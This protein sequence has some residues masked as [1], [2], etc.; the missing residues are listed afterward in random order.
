MLAQQSQLSL[1][2]LE[3]WKIVPFFLFRIR[4]HVYLSCQV[5]SFTHSL[6]FFFRLVVQMMD[7]RSAFVAFFHGFFVVGKL[8]IAVLLVEERVGE[9]GGEG[10]SKVQA[11]F[12]W[13]FV[14]FGA[15]SI[16]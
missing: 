12:S 15:G 1:S 5:Q 2:E 8:V 16:G 3:H 14:F 11:S 7:E 4:H 13:Q 6:S 9:L 10:L